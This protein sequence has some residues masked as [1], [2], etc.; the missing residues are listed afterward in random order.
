MTELYSKKQ[1]IPA[2]NWGFVK[3][4]A[5]VE[6]L[7]T[8]RRPVPMFSFGEAGGGQDRIKSA[9][10]WARALACMVSPVI[11]M[12]MQF[13]RSVAVIFIPVVQSTTYMV[14]L[15]GILMLWISCSVFRISFVKKSLSRRVIV[16]SF[17][18]TMGDRP[19]KNS[20]DIRIKLAGQC[21]GNSWRG[22]SNI[23]IFLFIYPYWSTF[24]QSLL[25]S[26]VPAIKDRGEETRGGSQRALLSR[27]FLPTSGRQNRCLVFFVVDIISQK[28]TNKE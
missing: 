27:V 10:F 7:V 5:R 19:E 28:R 13:V 20:I 9:I 22:Y 18:C 2:S 26:A 8:Q 12:C 16:A 17:I 6:S 24:W 14:W 23:Q 3:L 11:L 21:S 15:W 1:M 25:Y 4:P